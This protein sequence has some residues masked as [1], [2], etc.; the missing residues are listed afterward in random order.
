MIIRVGERKFQETKVPWS[1]SSTYGTFAPG[2]ERGNE[3]SIIPHSVIILNNC[4]NT[5]N[6]VGYL[7][8][9]LFRPSGGAQKNCQ[10]YKTLLKI[11]RNVAVF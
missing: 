10:E 3:S 1:E 6:Y 4:L 11:A 2:S 7:F 8:Q 9:Y 5:A